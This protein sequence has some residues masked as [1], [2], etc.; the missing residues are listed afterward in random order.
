MINGSPIG[1]NE[2]AFGSQKILATPGIKAMA[3]GFAA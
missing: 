1:M 2:E 3:P